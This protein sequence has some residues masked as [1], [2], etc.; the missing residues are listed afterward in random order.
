MKKVRELLLTI[1]LAAATTS[2]VAPTP[3]NPYVG[4]GGSMLTEPTER[5]MAD[6]RLAFDL[7]KL[8]KFHAGVSTKRDVVAAFGQPTWW[9]SGDDGYSRL[10]YDF[11]TAGASVNTPGLSPATFV[12]D[13]NNRLVDADYPESYKT[14]HV[15]RKPFSYAYTKVFAGL[16]PGEIF[17]DGMIPADWVH[18]AH[19]GVESI[20]IG[21]YVRSKIHVVNVLA[22]DISERNLVVRFTI[23][24]MRKPPYAVYMLLATDK[25][26]TTRVLDWIPAPASARGIYRVRKMKS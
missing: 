18:D 16:A 2:C 7:A 19:D 4:D 17:L 21:G 24:G 13:A 12:F 5:D 15:D 14:W 25:F 23:A 22:G 1:L 8:N 20:P 6:S 9:T 3:D 11:H 10:G 26:G